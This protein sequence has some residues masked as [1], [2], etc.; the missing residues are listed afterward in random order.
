MTEERTEPRDQT[1]LETFCHKAAKRNGIVADG[2]AE[3]K[4]SV[5]PLKWNDSKFACDRNNPE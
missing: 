3:V 1:A 4:G 5:C 2:E